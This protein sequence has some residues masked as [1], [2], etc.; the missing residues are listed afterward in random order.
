MSSFDTTLAPLG[1]NLAVPA[2]DEADPHN[3]MLQIIIPVGTMAPVEVAP[4]QPLVIQIGTYRIPIPKQLALEL[5]PKLVEAA[6]TLP[7][8]VERPDI[9]IPGQLDDEKLGQAAAVQQ[10]IRKGR[11]GG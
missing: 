8:P 10:A 11:P 1:F 5:G 7:D 4:G 3:P 6:E 2:P 9:V